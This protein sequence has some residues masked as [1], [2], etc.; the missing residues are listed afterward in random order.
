MVSTGTHE[1]PPERARVVL[2]EAD[3]S[4]ASRLR[5]LLFRSDRY[6]VTIVP[7]GQQLLKEFAAREFDLLF[8]D[9]A[10]PGCGDVGILRKLRDAGTLVNVPTIALLHTKRP[11]AR[12]DAWHLGVVDCVVWP[13]SDEELLVRA[14]SALRIGKTR[15]TSRERASDLAGRLTCLAFAEV[16][17]MISSQRR[18]GV[19]SLTM[20]RGKAKVLFHDGRIVHAT[21]LGLSGHAAIFALMAEEH[22]T[23]EFHSV[24]IAVDELSRTV[25]WNPTALIMEGARLIDE[26][27]AASVLPAPVAPVAPIEPVA[28]E[29]EVPSTPTDHG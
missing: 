21:F 9:P 12:I 19:L 5:L 22:G 8:V 11:P 13:V 17:S 29:P 2:A 27:R 4:L 28:A 7:D 20:P 1:G 24:D 10:L 16:V 14:A 23:F 26:R 6:L 3:S 25:T 18:G 15:E